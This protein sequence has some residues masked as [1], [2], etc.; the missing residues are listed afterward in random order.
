[1]VEL[2]DP[3]PE[4]RADKALELLGVTVEQ[5]MAELHFRQQG[6]L[7]KARLEMVEAARTGRHRRSLDTAEGGGEVEMMIPAIAYHYWGSRLGYACWEDPQFRRE[8]LRDNDAA[9]VVSHSQKL[10]VVNQWAPAKAYLAR[11]AQNLVPNKAG[12][13]RRGR[14]AA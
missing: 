6:R 13:G 11:K 5:V 10:T 1:M 3:D 4:A 7:H 12:K 14:W 9:R 2:I 8:F